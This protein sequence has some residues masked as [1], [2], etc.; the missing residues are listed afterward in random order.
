M[1]TIEIN[2][3]EITQQMDELKD[4]KA[5]YKFEL[6]AIEKEI[7]KNELK[8]IAVLDKLGAEEVQHGVY[9][10]GWKPIKRT[11]FDQKLFSS[12]N[13]DL[14]EKYKLTKESTKFEFKINK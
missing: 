6:D 12:E 1:T 4:Q 9:S 7:E 10:F 11:A 3:D 2:L 8:L 13:P 5:R 14:F